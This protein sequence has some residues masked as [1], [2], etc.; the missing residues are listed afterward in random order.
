MTILFWDKFYRILILY[1]HYLSST[2]KI[3][4]KKKNILILILLLLLPPPKRTYRA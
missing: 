4:K 3:I 1:A 2:L